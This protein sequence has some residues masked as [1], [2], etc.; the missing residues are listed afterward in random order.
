MPNKRPVLKRFSIILRRLAI[1]AALI[2][3][4]TVLLAVFWMARQFDEEARKSS[5]LMIK[6]GLNSI[7]TQNE[8]RAYDYANWT[9]AFEA[10]MQ[11][12]I[13]WIDENMGTGAESDGPI[14]L[15]T[16][17]GGPFD[18]ALGW[19]DSASSAFGADEFSAFSQAGHDLAKREVLRPGDPAA[20]S[21]LTIDGGLWSFAVNWIQPHNRSMEE[22]KIPALLVS[23]VRI[24]AD[25]AAHL[26][27]LFLIDDIQIV[28]SVPDADRVQSFPVRTAR[29]DTVGF[30]T[31]PAP[32]PGTHALKKMAWPLTL[33]LTLALG[34]LG[35]GAIVIGR[36]A[37]RFERA[38]VAAEAADKM[39][40]EFIAS[41]SHELRTPMNGIVGML[42]LLQLHELSPEQSE[43]VS[44]ASH[45]AETQVEMIDHLLAFGQIESG[46]MR[47]SAG[48]FCPADT[49]REVVALS[50][51]LAREKNLS[52]ELCCE[53]K[54]D[55]VLLGDRLA[56]RQIATNLIGNAIKFTST[57][58]IIVDLIVTST[59]SG[60]Q[61]CLAVTDSGP[62][63]KPA[64]IDRIFD[65]FVQVDGSATRKINGVGLGLA[66]S[67]RLA[68]EMNGKLTVESTIGSGSTFVFEVVLEA[69]LTQSG[70]Y[71]NAA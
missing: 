33:S 35:I 34:A 14:H 55:K 45:S 4:V 31:W 1:S 38:L 11:K 22:E 69:S 2:V 16:I 70:Q 48:P 30:I 64:D 42:E 66:I 37:Q 65:R 53:G 56:I 57:G 58:K 41:L 59:L 26:R 25:T 17:S 49:I 6:S 50:L 40:S 8:L 44:I 51:P 29:G 3:S 10:V 62:G 46:N 39:K 24:D 68:R 71:E 32:R 23:A 15:L 54:V 19:T 9:E 27:E 5:Y 47:L 18:E 43:L 21:F 20:S 7:V 12:D 28:L 13:D 63:I 67:Q 61:I 60:Y 36:L 52:L